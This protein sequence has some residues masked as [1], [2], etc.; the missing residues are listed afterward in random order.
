MIQSNL[1]MLQV[2]LIAWSICQGSVGVYA[3]EIRDLDKSPLDMAVFRP[4]GQ[5]ADPVARIIYSRP[6]KNDREIFGKLV[7]FDRLW[8]TG[9][10]QTTELNVYRDLF[11]QGKRLPVGSYTMYTIPRE[12][13]WTIVINSKLYTWGDYDYEENK[14]V[15]RFEVLASRS[16][17]PREHLG[18]AFDGNDGEGKI[19]LAWDTTEV[20][21]PFKY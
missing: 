3:Q 4:D 19:L 11:F 8:R 21:I 6:H 13:N 15:M 9:A 16:Q 17:E 5:T 14:D 18:M 2:I 12:K 7:P 1:N 20:Y 10:N